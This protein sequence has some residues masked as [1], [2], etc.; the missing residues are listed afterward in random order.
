[1]PH[2]QSWMTFFILCRPSCVRCGRQW[3]W[4]HLQT[5]FTLFI[6]AG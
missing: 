5:Q 4:R 3:H 6:C 2:L 1:M